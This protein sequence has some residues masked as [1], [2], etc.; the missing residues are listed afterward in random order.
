[1]VPVTKMSDLTRSRC[2]YQRFGV[3]CKCRNDREPG[4]EEAGRKHLFQL[5]PRIRTE[6]TFKEREHMLNELGIVIYKGGASFEGSPESR[7]LREALLKTE[8]IRGKERFTRTISFCMHHVREEDRIPGERDNTVA[9]KPYPS[10]LSPQQY[11]DS[12]LPKKLDPREKNATP[13][14]LAKMKEAGELVNRFTDLKKEISLERHEQHDATLLFESRINA[15]SSKNEEL[16]KKL[17][18]LESEKASLQMQLLK[19]NLIGEIMLRASVCFQKL[20]EESEEYEEGL[21]YNLHTVREILL[22]VDVST[23]IYLSLA[24][25]YLYLFIDELVFIII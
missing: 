19:P 18:H 22:R 6:E 17:E 2:M 14:A 15:L 4:C 11:K 20:V 12:K 9:C 7:L 24:C 25:N 10:L 16:L 21:P 13:L 3:N 5:N 8:N 1:M 23:F